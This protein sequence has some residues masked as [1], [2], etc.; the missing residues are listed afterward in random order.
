[1]THYNDYN[2][3]ILTKTHFLSK[4]AAYV[5]NRNTGYTQNKKGLWITPDTHTRLVYFIKP[6]IHL[7]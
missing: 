1:M 7:Y 3:N 6:Q 2:I 4:Y 5:G